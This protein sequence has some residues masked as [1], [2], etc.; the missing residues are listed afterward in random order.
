[1][2]QR[3]Q[4]LETV[5]VKQLDRALSKVQNG[6]ALC[7]TTVTTTIGQVVDTRVLGKVDKWNSSGKAWP[8]WSWGPSLT[9]ALS[10]S[11]WS[12]TFLGFLFSKKPPVSRGSL[13]TRR[14]S[15]QQD[16]SSEVGGPSQKR[17]RRATRREERASA[18]GEGDPKRATRSPKER[19][20][21]LSLGCKLKVRTLV[22]LTST[23]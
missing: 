3:L 7:W 11:E 1:M 5:V 4:D 23:F 16:P 9:L 8:K 18:L 17:G 6:I 2:I 22:L 14:P 19:K 12:Y 15:F 10:S 21:S 13:L 20:N